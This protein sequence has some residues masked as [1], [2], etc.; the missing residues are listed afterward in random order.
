[1]KRY[2]IIEFLGNER[3]CSKLEFYFYKIFFIIFNLSM[4]IILIGVIID[5]FKNI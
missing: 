2:F 5:C 3:E 1:M 4:L